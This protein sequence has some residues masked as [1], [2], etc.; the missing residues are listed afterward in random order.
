MKYLVND[1][2]NPSSKMKKIYENLINHIDDPK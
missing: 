1:L 2:E